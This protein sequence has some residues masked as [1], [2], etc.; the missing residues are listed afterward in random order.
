MTCQH[1]QTWILDD[2]HRCSR[3]GRRVR[4]APARISPATYPIAAT[5]TAPAYDFD[6]FAHANPVIPTLPEGL[7]EGQ[8]VLFAPVNEPRVIPFDTLTTPSEREAIRQRASHNRPEP[9]KNTRVDGKRNQRNRNL[10]NQRRLEFQGQEATVAQPRTHVMCDAP[11]ATSGIRMEAAC[12]DAILMI[13]GCAVLLGVFWL[14]GGRVPLDKHA[15]AFLATALLTIPIAYKLIWAFAGRDTPGLRRAG[16]ELVDFD[17]K[18]PSKRKRYSWA[19]G[20][21][22]SLLAGGIGMI[23]SLVD[24]DKLTWHD[25]IAAAFPTFT[26][27]VPE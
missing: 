13:T 8:G 23:W 20:G 12:L 3:C 21:V 16:L 25:H 5:A 1:C 22:L 9:V 18:R 27:E 6:T 4:S 24:E 15:L 14:A 10:S 11:V 26:S 19:L 2:D 17:G 7:R